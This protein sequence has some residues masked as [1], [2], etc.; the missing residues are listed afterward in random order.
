MAQYTRLGGESAIQ[1]TPAARLTLQPVVARTE[2][3]HMPW[4]EREAAPVEQRRFE[5]AVAELKAIRRAV[6]LGEPGSG[7][8]TTLYKLAADLIDAALLDETQPIPVMVRLGGWTDAAEPFAAFL[9]RSVGELAENWDERLSQKRI[10]LLLDGI[11][12]IPAGQQ[13]AKYGQVRQFLA[14]HPG[15]MALV[16]CREQDYPPD[17]DLAL[18]RVVVA[19]LDPVR[20]YQFVH[21]YLDAEYGAQAGDDLFWQLAGEKAAETYRRF[22]EALGDKLA[23]PFAAFWLAQTLPDDLMWGWEYEGYENRDWE[24][25]LKQRAHPASLLLLA[26]NPYMLFMLV[27]VYQAY[28]QTLPANRGQLFDWFTSTLLRRERVQGWSGM[29]CCAA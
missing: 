13:V 2:Y 24:A 1:R 9:Q 8:T 18:D 10:A 3:T 19:P 25:W 20:I 21:N 12:E 27:D 22:N 11:N 28:D 15:L 5:D 16:S 4:R 6:L 7:K 26:A 17:R 23:D 29:L 14:Q